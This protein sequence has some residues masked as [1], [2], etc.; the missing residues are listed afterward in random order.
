MDVGGRGGEAGTTAA[1]LVL[2]C[3]GVFDVMSD[4]E[5]VQFVV[6][7]FKELTSGSDTSGRDQVRTQDRVRS[8]FIPGTCF[9]F[10]LLPRLTSV[11]R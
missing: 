5:C 7:K 4:Q 8:T 9:R 3:D 2:A 11:T 1:L 10:F 6:D